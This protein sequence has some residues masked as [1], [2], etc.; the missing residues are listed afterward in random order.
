MWK[1]QAKSPNGAVFPLYLGPIGLVGLWL[2]ENTRR[3]M[4]PATRLVSSCALFTKG[5]GWKCKSSLNSQMT[6][7]VSNVVLQ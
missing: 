6:C 7:V 5:V 2:S 4:S 3:R 1:N